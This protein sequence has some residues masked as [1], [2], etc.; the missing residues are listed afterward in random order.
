MCLQPLRAPC[1]QLDPHFRRLSLQLWLS[2]CPR[3]PF[4]SVPKA[5]GL[6]C[7]RFGARPG[8][9]S[10][11]PLQLV[12]SLGLFILSHGRPSSAGP[13]FGF[14]GSSARRMMIIIKKKIKQTL[15]AKWAGPGRAQTPGPRRSS[16][17][18]SR[19]EG[20]RIPSS[21]VTLKRGCG[22]GAELRAGL[23][24][25]G[26]GHGWLGF[27][28]NFPVPCWPRAGSSPGPRCLASS[29]PGAAPV[30]SVL[31]HFLPRNDLLFFFS[32]LWVF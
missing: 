13:L 4:S 11:P 32:P 15:R 20:R 14:L 28:R 27:C 30:L 6:G 21:C 29:L 12:L 8:R 3:N 18:A 2:P 10:A 17:G 1:S 25:A 26:G 31:L 22:A 16:W 9:E 24:A 19:A 7:E 23:C 5:D